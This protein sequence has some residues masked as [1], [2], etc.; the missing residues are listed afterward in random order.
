M[1]ASDRR[2]DAGQAVVLVLVVV[3]MVVVCAV[4]MGRFATRVVTVEQA[5]V[6]ADAA[7]LAG[8]DGG[9]AAAARL[10]ERNGGRLRWFRASGD[11]VVVEVEVDGERAVARAGRAP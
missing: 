3:V 7:A 11:D 1:R 2:N 4:A 10:A 9:A 8:V 5:Q 6:A